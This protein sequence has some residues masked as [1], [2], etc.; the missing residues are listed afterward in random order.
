MG[1]RL[2]DIGN[3]KD[4]KKNKNKNK[5]FQKCFFGQVFFEENKKLNHFRMK[6]RNGNKQIPSCRLPGDLS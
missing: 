2:N 5:Q 1:V 3:E 6:I 4:G